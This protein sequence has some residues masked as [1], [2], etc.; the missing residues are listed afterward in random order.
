[1]A[2]APHRPRHR[3]PRR[4]TPFSASQPRVDVV[5]NAVSGTRDPALAQRAVAARAIADG[6]RVLVACGGDRTVSTVAATIHAAPPPR[7]VLA[8]VP[9]GTA[10][11]L[12]AALHIPLRPHRAAGV[13]PPAPRGSA[14]GG[15]GRPRPAHAAAGRRR[16]GS[17][18]RV[19]R[20]APPQARVR[21][22][23]VR[24]ERA[25]GRVAPALVFM[26]CA[27]PCRERSP[28]RWPSTTSSWPRCRCWASPSPT[29]RRPPPCWRWH[30]R[31]RARRRARR[32]GVRA[33][34]AAAR[35]LAHAAAAAARRAAPM[36]EIV[37]RE[38]NSNQLHCIRVCSSV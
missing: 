12:A 15:G 26:A 11:A 3:H 36:D 4:S 7:S 23:G 33:R 30:R 19:G 22:A 17:A 29:P 8:V 34:A 38:A 25:G 1:M 6:M 13:Q 20:G 27:T 14:P 5:F 32:A 9:R 16:T 18:S 10:N 37:K 35:R 21:R 31:A 2:R 24:C 28:S